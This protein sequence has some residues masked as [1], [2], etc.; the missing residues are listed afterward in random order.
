MEVAVQTSEILEEEE[1]KELKEEEAVSVAL[2]SPVAGKV[3]QYIY[4]RILY[5][6]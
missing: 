4:D 1:E 3:P 6:Y 5:Y 2:Q